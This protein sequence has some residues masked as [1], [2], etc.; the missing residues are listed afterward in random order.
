MT[1]PSG[2][3]SLT[4][5]FPDSSLSMMSPSRPFTTIAVFPAAF[6]SETFPS[7]PAPPRAKAATLRAATSSNGKRFS[8]AF[9]RMRPPFASASRD[10]ALWCADRMLTESWMSMTLSPDLFSGPLWLFPL[11]GDLGITGTLLTLRAERASRADH[12][13]R[14]KRTVSPATLA[15]LRRLRRNSRPL[16]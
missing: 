2:P 13:S 11:L 3:L 15:W 10:I 1:S 6:L 14:A 9:S 16:R 7:N 12:A 8:A 4:P 5:C